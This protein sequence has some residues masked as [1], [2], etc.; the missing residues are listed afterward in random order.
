MKRLSASALLPIFTV[1]LMIFSGTGK[2]LAQ[3]LTT[4]IPL[5]AVQSRL[6]RLAPG[7]PSGQTEFKVDPSNT[8]TIELIATVG[9]LKTKIVSPS[10]QTID[11]NTIAGLGGTFTI[12][13]GGPPDS[14]LIIPSLSP[15]FHYTYSFPSLG[16]GNYVVQFEAAPTLSQEVA[17]ISEMTTDSK[18][19]TNLFPPAPV[20]TLGQTAVLTA[21]IFDGQAPVA[22]ANVLVNVVTD[23]GASFSLNLQDDGGDGDAT[24]G[25]GLY[26]GVF[27]PTTVGTYRALAK[28]TGTSSSGGTFERQ[29][30]TTLSVVPKNGSLVGTF[31]DQG[32]D[33]NGDGLFDQIA[34]DVPAIITT[35]GQFQAFVHLKTAQGKPLVSSA[36][37]VLQPGTQ[38]IRVNFEAQDLLD[39][40]ENGPYT[41]ELVELVFV[42]AAKGAIPQD[43]K[44]NLGQTQPYKLSQLQQPPIALTGVISDQGVDDNG[45]KL[46]DRLLTSVQVNVLASGSYSWSYKLTDVSSN[47]IDFGS[48]SGSLNVGLNDLTV[49][50]DGKKISAS[51]KNGPYQLTDLLLQGPGTSLVAQTLGST[52]PYQASQFESAITNRPPVANAGPDQTVECSSKTGTPVALDGSVSSDPDNDPLTYEW[53]NP[54][55][56]VVASTAKATVTLP[57]GANVL[58][59]N[60]KDGKGGTASDSTT[61]TVRDTTAPT[62]KV[63]LTPTVLSPTKEA[64]A[65]NKDK[66]ELIPI[67]ASISSSDACS[68]SST[69]TL[70][71]ITSNQPASSN[72]DI[73]EASFGTDDRTFLLR[74]ATEKDSDRIYTVTY[75]VR[76]ASGNTTSTAA[77]VTALDK[78][79]QAPLPSVKEVSPSKGKVG[80]KVKIKGNNLAGTTSVTFNSVPASFTVESNTE[81]TTTVPPGATTGVLIITTPK[82]TVSPLSSFEVT[83]K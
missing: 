66:G 57:L 59:L 38:N 22:N 67:S 36:T 35:S 17:V 50:F 7:Q 60:V 16:N 54:A 44:I 29:S 69:V 12:I 14:P 46:F 40:G 42:D 80:T 56:L 68:S 45:N 8:I 20:L 65:D 74:A 34:I 19:R 55:N 78:K 33:A 70:V 9:D 13:Q 23:S 53:R 21:P 75:A 10:G 71:S 76:D 77:T 62:L 47:E 28:I 82:G 2:I 49:T 37:A 6:S 11:P 81:I 52:K 51:G 43:S 48:G 64:K 41:V 73:Q 26:S 25:D 1:P 32:V 31:S 4:D 15:G 3:E 61:I 83:A 5:N 24:S 18:I 63:S 79:S 27:T 39:L 30:A 72:N 58:T